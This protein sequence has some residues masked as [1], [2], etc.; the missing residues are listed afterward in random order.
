MSHSFANFQRANA[1]SGSN[2]K[3]NPNH[4]YATSFTVTMNKINLVCQIIISEYFYQKVDTGDV[5]YHLQQA[6]ERLVSHAREILYFIGH[7]LQPN[8]LVLPAIPVKDIAKNYIADLNTVYSR[9][10]IDRIYEEHYTAE[11]RA[12][13][14]S[15]EVESRQLEVTTDKKREA[16]TM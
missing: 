2:K 16:D 1:S 14:V 13:A 7:M 6:K 10:N 3:L 9:S 12:K 8:R 11:A 5:S 15:N 4:Q